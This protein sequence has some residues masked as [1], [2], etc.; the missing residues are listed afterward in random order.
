M[1]DIHVFNFR[2]APR[3]PQGSNNSANT[4]ID[5]TNDLYK[6]YQNYVLHFLHVHVFVV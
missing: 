3:T 5:T 1:M 4:K 2:L 6:H